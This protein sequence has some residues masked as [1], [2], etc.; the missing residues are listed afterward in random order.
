MSNLLSFFLFRA[1]FKVQTLLT[2]MA[3]NLNGEIEG[4]QERLLLLNENIFENN[5]FFV[6]TVTSLALF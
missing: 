6:S 3:A 2:N 4:R 1:L 5:L